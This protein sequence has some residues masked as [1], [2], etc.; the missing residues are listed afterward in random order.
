MSL[1]SH[2][3][4]AM[5]VKELKDELF[6]HQKAFHQLFVKDLVAVIATPCCAYCYQRNTA[7]GTYRTVTFVPSDGD[8]GTLTIQDTCTAEKKECN[9]VHEKT[10]NIDANAMQVDSD[11]TQAGSECI[12]LCIGNILWALF[13]RHD[14]HEALHILNVGNLRR[15]CDRVGTV[16]ARHFALCK[17][18]LNGI[19]YKRDF[20]VNENEESESFHESCAANSMWLCK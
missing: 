18:C 16:Q 6:S 10:W 15:F 9:L 20:Q 2:D 14:R 12:T 17:Y 7:K 19:R 8:V 11:S 1:D 5:A 13:N 3:N 4:H